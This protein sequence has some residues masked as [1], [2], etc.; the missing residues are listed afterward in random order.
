MSKH[1]IPDAGI[2]GDALLEELRKLKQDDVKWREGRTFSLVYHLNDDH[3]KLVAD[4]YREF[5]SENYLN[6]FA[7]KS[8]QGLERKVVSMSAD[9]L[10]GD[11]NVVGTFTSGGTESILLSMYAYREWA[12]SHKK[13]V[14][15]PEVV[16]PSSI[17]PAFDKA[18][19]LFGL[20]LNRVAVGGDQRADMTAM[21]KAITKNTI[22]IC[23]SAPSYPYGIMDP[24]PQLGELALKHN[25]PLHVDGCIGGFMLPWVE[26][27]GYPV[28]EWDFR[29]AG[30][31][32]ISA[33]LHK[34]GYA[35]KGASVLLYRSEEVL[36]HQIFIQTEWIGGVYASAT[37]LGS[38]TAGPIAAAWT[39]MCSL[40]KEGYMRVTDEIMTAV[41]YLRESISTIPGLEIVGE[42]VMNIIGYQSTTRD[43]DVYVVADQLEQ[44]G[45]VVD[46]QQFPPTIHMTVMSYNKPVLEQ[47]IDDLRNAV[48]FARSNPKASG[49]GQAA[50]YGTMA[51]VPLR[52]MVE[53]NVRKLMMTLYS[54]REEDSA[55]TETSGHTWMGVV[56]RIL[57]FLGR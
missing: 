25:L 11:D 40:G 27:L 36:Q 3:Q 51:R 2:S 41:K 14:K 22:L 7:F 55:Q 38:R 49:E 39:A 19:H 31:T 29:V 21:E 4:A 10:N 45:W 18:A 48:D 15:N 16:V 57:K 26:A 12:R 6:P 8:V 50:M 28:P 33:D 32:S 17:H 52:G 9:L 13:Q 46:R 5:L 37:I 24:I 53:K 20:T 44:R 30:V 35:A 54:A 56:N 43:V 42:P 34:F 47:Y 1:I 23:G